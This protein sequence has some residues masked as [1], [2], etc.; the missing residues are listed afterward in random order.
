MHSILAETYKSNYPWLANMDKAE[1]K[2]IMQGLK[3]RI[4][5][6]TI[7]GSLNKEINDPTILERSD[8]MSCEV[9]EKDRAGVINPIFTCQPCGAQYASIGIK[10]CIGIV[11]GG[12]GC[13]MFVRSSVLTTFQGK[14]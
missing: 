5:F 6:L 11:H 13:V 14:F 4:D 1:I 8:I 12:Q 10:D 9:K 3:E 7:T 2:L